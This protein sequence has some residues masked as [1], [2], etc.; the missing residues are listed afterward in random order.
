MFD[1]NERRIWLGKQGIFIALLGLILAGIA[2]G[3]GASL[4]F[5]IGS[6]IFYA[7]V[8]L[9]VVPLSIVGYAALRDGRRRERL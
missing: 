3:I 9:I 7:G 2:E 8:V 4:M 1:P 5:W 6:T